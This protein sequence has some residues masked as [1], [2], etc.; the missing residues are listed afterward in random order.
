MRTPISFVLA[1]ALALVGLAF[2]SAAE[3]HDHTKI[4]GPMNTW[5]TGRD[6]LE[7]RFHRSVP[8]G[9]F[10]DRISDGAREW[11]RYNRRLYF[12]PP[13]DS[14]P[15]TTNTIKEFECPERTDT[16]R[17]SI[18]H[19]AD[20]KKY[21]ADVNAVNSNC[22][23]LSDD[24][25]FYFRQFYDEK[26]WWISSSRN[27]GANRPDLQSTATHEFGH[28]TGFAT[29]YDEDTGDADKHPEYKSYCRLD[30]N[31]TGPDNSAKNPP[32]RAPTQSAIFA[33]GQTMCAV[34]IRGS[35]HRRTL[36]AHDRGTFRG[37]YGPR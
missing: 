12:V 27:I 28:A 21:G 22:R 35:T 5:P 20:T 33:G 31:Q 17:P 4:Y 9:R 16:P 23:K 10:R 8:K 6:R 32:Y 25:L 36:G 18:V 7:F 15:S 13:A 30:E 11:N 2:T 19:V 24:S 3:A 14:E 1:T 26:D 37:A 34:S 29:H